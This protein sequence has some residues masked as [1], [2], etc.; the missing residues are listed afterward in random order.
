M[1]RNEGGWCHFLVEQTL[2]PLLL[3]LR[4]KVMLLR[5]AYCVLRIGS[6]YTI[7]ISH[8]DSSVD[9]NALIKLHFI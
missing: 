5:V 8:M 1:H 7:S 2:D 9:Q 6:L 4:D 3:E